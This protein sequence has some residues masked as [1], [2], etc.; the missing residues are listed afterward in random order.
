VV[1]MRYALIPYLYSEFMKA[2]FN[3]ELLFAPL[4]YEY[5]DPRSKQVEDQLLLG[6]S[7][8]LAPIYEQNSRGRS[9]YLPE[10]MVLWKATAFEHLN[11]E[12]F[13]LMDEGYHFVDVALNVIPLYLKPGKLVVLT[14]PGNRVSTLDESNLVVLGYVPGKAIY[15]LYNDDGLTKGYKSGDSLKTMFKVDRLN[16][17]YHISVDTNDMALNTITFYLIDDNGKWHVI[18]QN[19]IMDESRYV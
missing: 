5:G 19:A 6:D 1:K 2:N 18:K 4:S 16:N 9:V 15:E 13:E 3:H 10:K 11:E 12:E 14:K 7:L 8:M 17:E